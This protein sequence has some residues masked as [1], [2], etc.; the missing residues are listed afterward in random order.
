MRGLSPIYC[1]VLLATQ[2]PSIKGLSPLNKNNRTMRGQTLRRVAGFASDLV[3]A[4]ARQT[5]SQ[6][7]KNF[8]DQIPPFFHFCAQSESLLARRRARLDSNASVHAC[9]IAL[10]HVRSV[11]TTRRLGCLGC[12]C[13]WT[14][15]IV[16]TVFVCQFICLS[17]GLLPWH[18]KLEVV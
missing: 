5:R 14:P 17:G 13:G 4:T 11:R 18:V 7:R 2:I 12:G 6:N 1:G 9:F 15:R 10:K 16:F 3:V 8:F